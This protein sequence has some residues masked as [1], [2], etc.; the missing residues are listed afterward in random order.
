MQC[1]CGKWKA[2]QAYAC[3]NCRFLDGDSPAEG[4][5]IEALRDLGGMA[6]ISQ[7]C[8]ELGIV[9]RSIM[10][11]AAR[12]IRRGRVRRLHDENH[13]TIYYLIVAMGAIQEARR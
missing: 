3:E 1:E 10:R 7:L 11:T 6:D 13:A 2:R 8:D 12:L 5:F 4:Q 9:H